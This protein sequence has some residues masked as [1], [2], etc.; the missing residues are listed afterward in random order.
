M[1][2][3][4]II[5]IWGKNQYNH[6]ALRE[7]DRFV[8]NRVSHKDDRDGCMFTSKIHAIFLR[9][10]FSCVLLKPTKSF[11]LLLSFTDCRDVG[12]FVCY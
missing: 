6:L 3:R 8:L 5:D 12:T 4:L 10:F 7:Y 9:H 2:L 11:F 1:A